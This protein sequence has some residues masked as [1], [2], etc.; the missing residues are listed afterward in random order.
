MKDIIVARTDTLYGILAPAGDQ[1]AVEYIYTLKGRDH[2][3]PF[4]ILISSIDQLLKFGITLSEIHYKYIDDYW[5]GPYSLIF[6][7][8]S[9]FSKD[10]YYP[11]RGT[12][13]LAF[14]LPNDTQVIRLIDQME[15][16]VVA[17]SCNPQGQIPASTITQAKEYFGNQ[18]NHY[19]D[20]GLV[21]QIK[22]SSVCLLYTSDA[23]DD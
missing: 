8:D 22:P 15:G 18:I 2:D 23:A 4:I 10:L 7:I 20:G 16:A 12:N 11:H 14:R 21:E 5:P 6:D 3:K 17:P 13:T 19:I 9:S 1:Y